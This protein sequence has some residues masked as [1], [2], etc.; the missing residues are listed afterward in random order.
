MFGRKNVACKPVLGIRI[1]KRI[2]MFLYLTDPDP[3]SGLRG[4]DRIRILPFS[5]KGVERTEIML[6]KEN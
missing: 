3:K 1:L 2:C 4:T 5:H 6:A